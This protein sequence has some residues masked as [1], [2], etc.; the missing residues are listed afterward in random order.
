M[1]R[2]IRAVIEENEPVLRDIPYQLTLFHGV[3]RRS[4]AVH[5]FYCL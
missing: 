5:M 1:V 3:N 2:L 4:R